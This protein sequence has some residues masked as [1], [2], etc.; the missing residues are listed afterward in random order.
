[1]TDTEILDGMEALLREPANRDTGVDFI[2]GRAVITRL[3][4]DKRHIREILA[5]GIT[6]HIV[7]LVTNKL[8]GDPSTLPHGS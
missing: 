3:P 6:P 1:V 8:T 2:L 4:R 7:R 5:A